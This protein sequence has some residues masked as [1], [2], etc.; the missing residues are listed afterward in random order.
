MTREGSGAGEEN[1]VS[2][3]VH[4]RGVDDLTTDDLKGFAAEH[5]PSDPA[6]RVEWIDDT[7]ANIVFSNPEAAMRAL[8]S[9]SQVGINSDT[10]SGSITQLRPAKP[11][12]TRPE[13]ELQ[14]RIAISSDVKRLRAYEASR[15][16]MMHPE[17]D[18][19]E[20]ARSSKRINSFGD[21]RKGNRGEGEQIRRPQRDR[22]QNYRPD[23][24]DDNPKLSVNGG[25]SRRSSFSGMSFTE[26]RDAI[27]RDGNNFRGDYYR[28]RTR[29]GQ[30]SSRDRSASPRKGDL[31]QPFSDGSLR[32]RRPP[33]SV[34]KDNFSQ[35]N[36]VNRDKELFPGKPK[37][38]ISHGTSKEL[39]PNKSVAAS[40][41]KELFPIKINPTHHRRSDAFDA[42]DETADLFASGM[43]LANRTTPFG[44]RGPTES[45]FGRLR[46]S[47]VNLNDGRENHEQDEGLSIKGASK[48]LTSGIS[49]RGTAE[50]KYAGIM[51]ELFPDKLG[52]SGKELFA[53][54]LHGRGVR[55]NM[56]ED[57]FY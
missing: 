16:Y 23:M 54:K 34:E 51:K 7:S 35:N 11:V 42:A 4:I 47:D 20:R 9:F 45:A 8:I 25:I 46:Q 15:F 38:G 3:K 17:H 49:I 43:A 52:N 40:L 24:Y 57:L 36:I 55:R 31:S 30:I 48:H 28:P 5:L 26:E 32:Q 12:P 37:V 13:S 53:E 1:T 29:N 39:F 19:R 6:L 14:V 27:Q 21:Y 41:K 56:A 50:A 10:L 18:P 2:H 22:G 33:Q 44:N